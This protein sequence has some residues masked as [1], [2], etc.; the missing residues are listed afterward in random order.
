MNDRDK[1]LGTESV[2]KLLIKF[3]IPAVTGMVVNA[4]YNV[5]DRIYVGKGVGQN[6]LSGLA[7][8]YPLMNIMMAFSMLIG[9]GSSNLLSIRLGERKREDAEKILNNALVLLLASALVVTV[10]G[11]LFLKPALVFFGA[12]REEILEPASAYMRIILFGYVFQAVGFGLNHSIRAEGSPR[13]AMGSMIIGAVLN[14]ILD[15]IFIFVFNMGV[16]GAAIATIISQAASALFVVSYFLGK[17]SM[18]KLKPALFRL[19]FRIVKGI[20]S[21][22][23]AAFV[24]QLA[25]S[26][27]LTLLNNSLV[28]YGKELSP[29]GDSAALA[30][31]AAINSVT[32]LILM[33][34]F[35]INQGVQPIIG[36]NYGACKYDRVLRAYRY[37]VMAAS[38]FTVLGF[39]AVM[40]FPSQIVSVFVSGD[41]VMMS[42]GTKAIRIILLLLPII[43]YQI[44]SSSYFQMVGKS[45][46]A[47]FLTTS[48][49]VIILI[50]LIIVLPIFWGLWG[51]VWAT[52][53]ADALSST[54]TSILIMRETRNLKARIIMAGE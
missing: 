29:A 11:L 38:V 5:V 47:L 30:A 6:G 12:Q 39:V 10:L 37:A 17:R 53:I 25:S 44:V 50:P 24:L 2:F 51:V 20:F 52:P 7:V 22:G 40:L 31:Y 34:V 41:E 15:P 18:I 9:I 16:E 3:S 19:D 54:I 42:F 4:L 13:T 35:G 21:V 28:I 14:T 48:R 1:L 45:H 8:A 36:Y 27:V 26:A 49:Q 23:S 33:P 46:L 43:G 32:M